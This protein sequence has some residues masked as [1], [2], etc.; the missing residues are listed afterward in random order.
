MRACDGP[1]Q[2]NGTP[3]SAEEER[4]LVGY[5]S[6]LYLV[7]MKKL[8][9]FIVES[10]SSPDD[11]VKLQAMLQEMIKVKKILRTGAPAVEI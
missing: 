10:E 5:F 4:L 6:D 2:R 11:T 7:F 3:R 1:A 9:A 8:S